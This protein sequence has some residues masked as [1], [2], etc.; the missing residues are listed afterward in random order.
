MGFGLSIGTPNPQLKIDTG[1][2]YETPKELKEISLNLSGVTVSS[3][4]ST[5]KV[6]TAQ[7]HG[8]LVYLID[9]KYLVGGLNL[10]KPAVTRISENSKIETSVGLG[11]LLGVGYQFDSS[12]VFEIKYKVIRYSI[13]ETAND[14]SYTATYTNIHSDGI[15]FQ[16]TIGTREDLAKKLGVAKSV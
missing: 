9:R 11:A 3:S 7:L 16:M 15:A 13:I 10:S 8:N 4:P 12:T 5:F 6:S 2:T 1:I 14:N